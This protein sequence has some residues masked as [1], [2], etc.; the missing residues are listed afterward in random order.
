SLPQRKLLWFFMVV[1]AG[2]LLLAFGRF[3]PFYRIIYALPGA[4]FFRNPAKFTH[5]VNWALIVLFAHGVHGLIRQYVQRAALT[6]DR[7]ERGTTGQAAEGSFKNW[8]AKAPVFDRRWTI[9]CIVA[10]AVS[11]LG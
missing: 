10:I 8:W 3:A 2:S 1:A 5:V 9:G 6:P 7:R 4:S 11:V